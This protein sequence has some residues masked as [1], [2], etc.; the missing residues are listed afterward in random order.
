VERSLQSGLQTGGLVDTIASPN[1]KAIFE[2]MRL[3]SVAV[4]SMPTTKP[5]SLSAN[6]N[7]QASPAGSELRCRRIQEEC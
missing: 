3:Y 6:A 2:T 5:K 7:A 1:P 4:A